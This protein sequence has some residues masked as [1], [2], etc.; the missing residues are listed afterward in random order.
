M[1]LKLCSHF[2]ESLKSLILL[3]L[4]NMNYEFLHSVCSQLYEMEIKW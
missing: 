3:L 4:Y 1:G 2:K